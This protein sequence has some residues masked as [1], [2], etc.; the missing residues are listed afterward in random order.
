[1]TQINLLPWREL[2][3]EQEKK[4]FTTMLLVCVVAAAF[5]VFLINSY[6]SGLVSNQI[7]RNQMLQKEINSMDAQL[8]EIKKLEKAREMLI[9]R[10]SVV[11]HLQSTRTLMVHLFDDLINVTPSGIYLIQVEGKND[12]I[13]VIGYTESNTFVSILMRNIENNDWLHTPVLG[14][15]KREENDKDKDKEKQQST[16]NEFKL[17]FVLAPQFQIGII[18]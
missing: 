3:R 13:S 2:K 9:S 12:I 5:I 14:E 16:E 18:L 17:T 1:M 15:I 7:T 6:A 10:M 8:Q 11:Q 4:L